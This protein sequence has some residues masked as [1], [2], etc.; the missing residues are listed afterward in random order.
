MKT[1]CLSGILLLGGLLLIPGAYANEVGT[2][3]DYPTEHIGAEMSQP[4]TETLPAG[5]G[6]WGRAKKALQTLS[7]CTLGSAT[8][9]LAVLGG[10]VGP[11]GLLGAGV[12][13]LICL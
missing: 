9:T 7:P 4:S 13:V 3:E 12:V 8:L 2:L 1:L 5:S 11:I 6:W 10:S